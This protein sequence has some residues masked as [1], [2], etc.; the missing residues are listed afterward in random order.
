MYNVRNSRFPMRFKKHMS[1][2]SNNFLFS[3]Q[4]FFIFLMYGG[5]PVS[6]QLLI[7]YNDRLLQYL[8][9]Q[10][11]LVHDYNHSIYSI[12]NIVTIKRNSKISCQYKI[13]PTKSILVAIE[14]NY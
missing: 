4:I 9:F 6:V 12:K 3:L 14:I 13:S 1:P 2:Q 11:I 10:I 5:L 8:F 7:N